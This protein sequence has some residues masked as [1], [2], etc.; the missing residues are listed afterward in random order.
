MIKSDVDAKEKHD[1]ESQLI[2]ENVDRY[3]FWVGQV[4]GSQYFL[5]SYLIKISSAL[6]VLKKY[7]IYCNPETI[8]ETLLF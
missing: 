3:T 2:M 4:L 5:F 8:P 1:L 6:E 7:L